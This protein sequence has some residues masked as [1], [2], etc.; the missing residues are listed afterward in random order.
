MTFEYR[1][2]ANGD[3]LAAVPLDGDVWLKTSPKGCLIPP[4][5]VEEVIAGIRG[6]ARPAARQTTGQ[7]DT[8]AA[9][10]VIEPQDHPGA[11]LYVRLRKAGE[12]HDTAQALI[13]AH[14]RMA[15]RQHTAIHGDAPAVG[16]LTEAHA[17]RLRGTDAAR[18][19][20]R[21]ARGDHA[22]PQTPITFAGPTG[23]AR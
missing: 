6:A 15:V 18:E 20:V 19:A 22:A 1:N 23:E 10:T 17:T 21:Q 9:P 7:D 5:R 3:R 16:Q 4:E 2:P 14:A 13:Y 8:G 11:D 12:D